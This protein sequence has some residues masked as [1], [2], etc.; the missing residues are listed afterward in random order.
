[1]GEYGNLKEEEETEKKCLMGY[2]DELEKNRMEL[3]YLIR[4]QRIARKVSQREL[5]EGICTQK[6]YRKLEEGEGIGDEWM[7]ECLLSRLHVQ[8]RLLEIMLSD[9]DF[10]RK[11]C[12]YEIDRLIRKGE[13]EKAGKLLEEYESKAQE[14]GLDR[15]YV[16]W[17]K[18]VLLGQTDAKGA[19]ALAKEALELSLPIAEAEHRLCGKVILSE[20]ELELYL[21]YRR[22]SS[23]FSLEEYPKLL[24][25]LKKSFIEECICVSCYFELVYE[26]VVELLK[27]KR[28]RECREMCMQT[29]LVLRDGNR[30]DYI[31]ELYFLSAI[32]RRKEKEDISEEEIKNFQQ[33]IKTAYYTAMSFGKKRVAEQMKKYCQEVYGWHITD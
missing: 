8:Y 9:E 3:S 2:Y 22:G 23:S 13:F 27:T 10:W 24:G 31:S 30:Y 4:E 1:M 7:A 16:L 19:G 29:I 21:L 14:D 26:F 32:A 5:Y 12:R 25:Q 11:E 33:E 28:Y 17:K 18:A 6:A 15:Q 20:M